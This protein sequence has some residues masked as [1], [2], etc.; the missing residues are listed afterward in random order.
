MTTE[1]GAESQADLLARLDAILDDL[2]TP[3][4]GYI[5]GFGFFGDMDPERRPFPGFTRP[6]PDPIQ[7][8]PAD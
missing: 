3:T 7:D 6:G 8:I 2:D 4:G 1:P 5:P